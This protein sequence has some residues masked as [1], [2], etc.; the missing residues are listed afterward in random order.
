MASRYPLCAPRTRR[1]HGVVA[2]LYATTG[3]SFARLDETSDG[4]TVEASLPESTAQCLAR[5][6]RE[7][8]TVYVGLGAG[9][10]RKTTDG[11]HTWADVGLAEQQVFSVAVSAADGAVYVGT[12]PSALFR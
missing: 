6:P 11:G 3:S 5:D 8:D 1:Q 4:W 2:R 7:P 9:G 12:E 10:V